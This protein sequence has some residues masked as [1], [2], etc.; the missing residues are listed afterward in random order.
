MRYRHSI[1][2]A[3][4]AASSLLLPACSD[5]DGDV[6]TSATEVTSADT[7]DD[8]SG[9][10]DTTGS[11]DTATDDTSADTS[12]GGESA[13]PDA[14]FEG[15]ISRSADGDH[16]EGSVT[17]DDIV[18]AI[19]YGY[20]SSNYTIYVGDHE[21]DRTVL[22]EYDAGNFSTDNAMTAPEGGLLVTMFVMGDPI[23]AGMTGEYGSG[24]PSPIVDTGGGATS[25][26]SN[27]AGSYTVIALEEDRICVEVDYTDDLQSIQGTVSAEIW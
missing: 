25:T 9:S 15:E 27:A 21:L 18:E 17:G 12:G 14:P 2:I 11:D 1:A 20:G 24:T 16:A 13:C 3:A 10:D 26:T 7:T 8:T 6:E 5:D 19:A 23:E 4:L 22:E